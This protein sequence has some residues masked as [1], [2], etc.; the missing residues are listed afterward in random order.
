MRTTRRN[1][2][3]LPD[4]TLPDKL[5]AV[6]ELEAALEGCQDILVVVPSHAFRIVIKQL[7]D[8][9]T[10]GARLLWATKGFET[11]S[12]KLLHSVVEEV[13]GTCSYGVLSG[14]TFALEVARGLPTAVTIASKDR[15]LA[16]QWAARV[17]NDCFRAYT[18]DDVIGLEIGGA[19]KNVMAIASGI[20]D[21][22]GFGANTRAALIT[23]GLHEIMLLGDEL[24][25][26][27]ETFMGLSGLGDLVLTCTDDLSRNRR[28]GLALAAGKAR[29]QAL[30]EI[31]Q[32]VEGLQTASEVHA[33]AAEHAVPMPIT[34]QIYNVLYDDTNPKD[35]VQAL[36]RREQKPEF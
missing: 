15:L 18:S 10:S 17:H 27:R 32:V 35:A 21:G 30:E 9:I 7:H 25:G 33:L 5:Q 36:F 3:Y 24:G 16:Q 6:D 8:H 14:P 19:V 12:H 34:E 2:R 4:I 26:K 11:G 13:C 22:L 20:S 23:R 29:E 28:F 31:G 1:D